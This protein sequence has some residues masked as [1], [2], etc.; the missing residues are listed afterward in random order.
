MDR[1]WF[2]LGSLLA[3]VA[4]AAGAFGAHGLENRLSADDMD[5]YQTAARYHIYHALALL[6]VSYAAQ[7]FG[8]GLVTAS[9]WLFV[10]GIILFSGA[11]YILALSG[12]KVLGAVA[13]I[14]GL[15]FLAGWA[16][17][18]IAAWRS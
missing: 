12:I 8:G 13:P 4:V 9:G 6:A 17:L 2:V 16:C 15:C 3:A 7:R 1:T 18:A 14:G 11:L 10:A 5:T